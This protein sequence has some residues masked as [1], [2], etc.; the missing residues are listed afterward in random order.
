[1]PSRFRIAALCCLALAALAVAGCAK[2][3]QR[4]LGLPNRPPQVRLESSLVPTG[5]AATVAARLRWSATDPDGRIDHYLVTSD[6]AAL[7]EKSEGWARTMESERA[8]LLKRALPARMTPAERSAPPYQL[9]AVRAVDDGGAVSDP[10]YRAFFGDDV[11]P[12]VTIV[13]PRPSTL[14]LPTVPPTFT[15]RWQGSDPDGPDG[16][17]RLYKFKLYRLTDFPQRWLAD[18]DTMLA[19]LAPTF[20]GWDSVKGTT[21]ELRLENLQI[22]DQYVFAITAIDAEGAYDPV[23]D[24]SKNL[25]VFSVVPAGSQGPRLTF[26]NDFF[27]YTFYTE[28]AVIPAEAPSIEIPAGRP[29]TLNWYAQPTLGGSLT[30]YRWVL[31]PA[32]PLDGSTRKNPHDLSHWSEWSLTTTS[33][34]LGPFPAGQAGTLHQLYVEARESL[35]FVSYGKV[36][37]SPVSPTFSHDLLIVDDTRRD[38][39]MIV[40]GHPDTIGPPRG[41]WPSAAELDT[42]LFALGGVRWRMTPPSWPYYQG[43]SPQ[44]IFTGYSYDTI[45]TRLGIQDPTQ[46]ISLDLLSHY[47]HVIWISSDIV[48]QQFTNVTSP[49]QPMTTLRFMSAPNHQSTLATWVQMGGQLWALGGAFAEGTNVGWNNPVND[50]P[51]RTYSAVGANPDLGPGRFMYDLTHWRSEFRV[52]PGVQFRVARIDQANPITRYPQPPLDWKGEPL[53]DPRFA[54]L[55]IQL[56]GKD[57]SSDPIWPSRVTSSFFVGNPVYSP[58]GV[59]LEFLDKPNVVFDVERKNP[60][61]VHSW[62]VQTLDTLYLAYGATAGML[63]PEEGEGVNACMTYYH[64]RDCGPVLFTGFDIWHWR[65]ADCVQLVDVVLRDVWGMSRMAQAR[66]VVASRAV[67]RPATRR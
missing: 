39:D 2:K 62:E 15:I 54:G 41:L 30:G 14:I 27:T 19:E 26:F 34:T 57:P 61:P 49:T 12:T 35:G 38:V 53:R 64:G 52:L 40:P 25:L 44:G 36:S 18:P 56:R 42:F 13:E 33:V 37:V 16:R 3:L 28:G 45:G 31:D 1:M 10:A 5:D 43:R 23:F 60:S 29:F 22:L 11:A 50:V 51:A 63:R 4:S 20:A 9:F 65:R 58:Y 66:P 67:S 48:G 55:P 21:T 47:R 17:P 7:H 8:I 32:D 24:R 46:V 59:D 6:L